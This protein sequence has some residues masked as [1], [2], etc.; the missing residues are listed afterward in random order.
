MANETANVATIRTTNAFTRAGSVL[1]GWFAAASSST[2]TN[3]ANGAS[4]PFASSAT[5]YA[6]WKRHRG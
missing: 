3:Y 1:D 4:Y 6:Q 5:L 2:G